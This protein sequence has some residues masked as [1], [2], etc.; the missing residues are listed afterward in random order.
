VVLGETER[1]LAAFA[2]LDPSADG[3]AGLYW[4]GGLEGD[5][6]IRRFGT[7]FPAFLSALDGL[8]AEAGHLRSIRPSDEPVPA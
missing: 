4:F 3:T 2:T 5:D 8:L 7:R 6:D 1:W